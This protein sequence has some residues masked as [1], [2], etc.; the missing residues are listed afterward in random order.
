MRPGFPPAALA[1][2]T[3]A[4]AIIAVPGGARADKVKPKL[5]VTPLMAAA[6]TTPAP[7]P[8]DPPGKAGGD[9]SPG[10]AGES[11]ILVDARAMEDRMAQAELLAKNSQPTVQWGGYVDFGF[12]APQGNGSGYVEDIGH[13][14][15]PDYSGFGWVFLGDILSPAVNSR[16]EVADLGTAP[17]VDRFDSINSRGAPGFVL[18]ELNL[19]LRSALT[20]TALISASV[21]FTPRTGSD[22]RLGDVFDVDLAQIEWLPTESQRTSIFAGKM[23]SAMGIEYRD[24]KSDHR[25]GITP[26]LISRYTIGTALG[27]KVRSKFGEDDQLIVAAAITNGSNTTEQFHFYD[28]VDSNAGKTA[29]GRL[30]VRLPFETEIGVSGSFGPQDRATDNAHPMF[31][32]GPDLLGHYGHV[33]LK[34]QWLTGRA[35]GSAAEGVYGLRLHQGGYVEIDAM[36]TPTW[37]F[38]GRGEFRDAL[39]WLGSERAYLT[40]SWRATAGI[41]CVITSRAVLKAE[42]LKNGEYGGLPQVRNDVFTSSLVLGL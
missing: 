21:N 4:A 33:D 15:R 2:F 34:A 13:L 27:L 32:V 36:V 3:A 5:A 16:G 26:S 14:I 6:A 9:E 29:S 19:S 18:N 41:R 17:G 28:E 37:G 24:R 38:L 22:F 35:D 31:F 7:E 11:A 1:F 8:D 10:T 23:E 20:P 39:V 40:K 30:A 12:F 25:F 42:Y